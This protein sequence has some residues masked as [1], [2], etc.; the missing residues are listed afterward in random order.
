MHLADLLDCTIAAHTRVIGLWQGG[1]HTHQPRTLPSWPV[2]EGEYKGLLPAH[3]FPV[4][5]NVIFCMTTRIPEG[6]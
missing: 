5:N 3:L 1:L 2:D 4:G 6:W